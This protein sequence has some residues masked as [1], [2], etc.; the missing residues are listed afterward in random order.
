MRL[1]CPSCRIL[2]DVPGGVIPETGRIVECPS[3][4][5]VWLQKPVAIADAE[6][7]HPA[8]TD[9][10]TDA[11]AGDDENFEPPPRLE[12][13]PEVLR[14][15]R[16]EAERETR[17]RQQ[18][19]TPTPAAPERDMPAARDGV[20]TETVPAPAPAPARPGGTG[21]ARG[22]LTAL[23]IAALAV[24]AYVNAARIAERVPQAEP[25]LTV[26]VEKV[27]A[28]RLWLTVQAQAMGL[29]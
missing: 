1:S 22:F 6:T 13:S 4:G 29:R 16:E 9:A 26:Y 3:C 8:P 27:N 7:M 25:A 18:D 10:E 23:V 15:L 17:L 21:F 20:A 19:A 11:P 24:L 2:Y 14:I 12:H 28:A 5:R